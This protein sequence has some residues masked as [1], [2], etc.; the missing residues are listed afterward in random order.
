MYYIF[1]PT[2]TLHEKLVDKLVSICEDKLCDY[3]SCYLETLEN[4]G[5]WCFILSTSPV[6]D[7]GINVWKFKN[8]CKDN[9]KEYMFL[10]GLVRL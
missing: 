3:V 5:R 10:E 1:H 7:S 4:G 6:I 8:I 2:Y 9:F